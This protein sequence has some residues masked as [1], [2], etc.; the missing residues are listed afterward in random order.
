MP[1]H[2]RFRP[3]RAVPAFVAVAAALAATLAG[4]GEPVR[5]FDPAR[6]SQAP[7]ECDRLA[8]HPDDPNRVAEG[9][10]QG[11]IDLPAAIAACERAVAADPRNPRLNYQL[12]RVYGY[13]GQGAKAIPYR[14][15][16]VDAD[17]PQALFVVG[18]ITLLGLNGQPQDTCAAA[19]LIRRSAH[20]GRLA[21]QLGFP[22]FVLAGRFG[23]C[24]AG[25]DAAEL[26]GFLAAARTQ[27]KGDFYQGLL[28]DS[29]EREL[30]ARAAAPAPAAK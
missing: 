1:I 20:Q 4:A 25:R 30:R 22:A 2:A 6:Y 19:E 7:T 27:I 28:V 14:K 18:Y 11:A 21:G 24:Q 17:Y 10:A 15:A 13:S 12:A 3:R 8:A 9:R 23:A 26:Q 29:L 5:P 16:A